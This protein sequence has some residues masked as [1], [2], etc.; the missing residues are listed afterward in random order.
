MRISFEKNKH[1]STKVFSLNTFISKNCTGKHNFF[2]IKIICV[3]YTFFYAKFKCVIRSE[4]F[5]SNF[6]ELVFFVALSVCFK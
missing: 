5:K 3:S 1:I 2:H 6:S 4:F